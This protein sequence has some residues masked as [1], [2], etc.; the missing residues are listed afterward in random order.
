MASGSDKERFEIRPAKSAVGHFVMRDR[1]E[2]E[3]I[4]A[5]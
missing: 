3:Q 1:N 2:L 5:R 4:S